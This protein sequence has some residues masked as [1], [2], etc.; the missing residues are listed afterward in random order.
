MKSKELKAD[1]MLPNQIKSINLDNAIPRSNELQIESYELT[2]VCPIVI[3][4][5]KAFKEM[6]IQIYGKKRSESS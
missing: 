5:I 6:K 3:Y 2:N 1:K 4:W